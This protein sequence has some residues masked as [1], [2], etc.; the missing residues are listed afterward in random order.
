M[1]TALLALLLLAAPARAGLYYSGEVIADL[2]ALWRG[3]LPDHR[4][5]RTLAAPPAP[6]AAPHPLRDAY[7]ADR[8]R[9]ARLAAERP[10]TADEAADLGAL[11]LRLGA[12]SDALAVLRAAHAKSPDHFHVAANLGTTWQ[13]HG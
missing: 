12:V 2:P 9:L 4:T 1:R 8:D 7:V 11:H 13:L 10:L 3:F 5:L 6:A